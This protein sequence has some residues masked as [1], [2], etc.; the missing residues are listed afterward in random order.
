V[1]VLWWLACGT[2]EPAPATEAAPAAEV[3][4]VEDPAAAAAAE[5]DRWLARMHDE[6]YDLYAADQY[7]RR[8]QPVDWD[9][10]TARDTA[11]RAR[12]AEILAAGGASKSIDFYYAALIY[13]H[14]PDLEDTRKAHELALHALTIEPVYKPAR[15]LAAASEDRILVSEGKPQK[16][17]TQST[18]TSPEGPWDLSEVDPTV[19]DAQRAQWD[20]PPLAEA[21]RRIEKMNADAA[22]AASTPP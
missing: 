19:T 6:L 11:R 9:A 10:V 1:T 21:R 8:A 13:Q 18:K 20:V 15:W 5:H 2:V 14:G 3:A 4:V 17:G 22:K 7:D 12:V 16:W